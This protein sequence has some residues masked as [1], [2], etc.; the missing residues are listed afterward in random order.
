AN[1]TGANLRAAT[2]TGANLAKAN[3]TGADLTGARL[4]GANVSGIVWSATSC[5]DGT[6]SNDHGGTCIG[7]LTPSAAFVPSRLF[8]ALGLHMLDRRLA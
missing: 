6:S 8:G 3:L 2:L 4:T 1:L 5:P 7:H